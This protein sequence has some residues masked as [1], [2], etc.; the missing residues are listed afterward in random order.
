VHLAASTGERLPGR[1]RLDQL[2]SMSRPPKR[3]CDGDRCGVLTST[4]KT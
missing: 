4:G 1:P 2:D 3:G